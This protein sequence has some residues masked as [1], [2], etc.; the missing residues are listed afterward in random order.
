MVITAV[1][2]FVVWLGLAFGWRTVAHWR[3]TGDSGFRGVTDQPG[4]PGWWGG[5]LFAIALLAAAGGLVAAVAGV[6]PP[7]LLDK[8][9]VQWVGL[10]LALVGAMATFLSQ[11]AMGRSWRIGVDPSERTELVTAGMFSLVR[12]PIF[13]ACILTAGGV[14]LMVPNPILVLSVIA[15]VGAIELQV[16]AVEEPY[17]LKTHGD[18][19]RAYA[20]KVGRLVPGLGLV[21]EPT[22]SARSTGR[23]EQSR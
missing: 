20:S 23:R 11:T 7:G 10:A 6:Q 16:R 22:V 18:A 17:L 21:R 9:A 12:N 15:L 13:T 3:R 19:Y 2:L 14:A 1:V 4:S 5:V 8:P